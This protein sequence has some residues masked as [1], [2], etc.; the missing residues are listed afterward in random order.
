[1]LSPLLLIVCVTSVA[2]QLTASI[3]SLK[4]VTVM[5][6]SANMSGRPIARLSVSLRA[7]VLMFFILPAAALVAS[8]SV[9]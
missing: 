2:I 6:I 8:A 3:T 7:A 9:L 4:P 5:G 1:M